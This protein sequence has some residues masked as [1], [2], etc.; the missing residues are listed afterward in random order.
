MKQTTKVTLYSTSNCTHCRQ[1]KTFLQKKGVRFMEFDVQRNQRA[2]KE[3]QRLGARGVP[4]II[5]GTTRL[6][7]FNARQLEQALAKNNLLP[8]T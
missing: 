4:V 6:D 5:I 8:A 7:G 2:L 3:F 1:A